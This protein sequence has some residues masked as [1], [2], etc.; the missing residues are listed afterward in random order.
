MRKKGSF[1]LL[2]VLLSL[3]LFAI[4]FS[5]LLF[6]YSTLHIQK[7][8]EA[9]QLKKT[10]LEKNLHRHLSRILPKA[11]GKVFYTTHN[12]TQGTVG[13]G[14]VFTFDHGPC[15]EP[16][17]SDVVLGRLYVDQATHTLCLGI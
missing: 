13:T 14:L 17:L 7:N 9:V 2:E 15:R 5:S 3:S 1:T 10:H 6:W 11:D 8:K 12:E 16:L 4:V